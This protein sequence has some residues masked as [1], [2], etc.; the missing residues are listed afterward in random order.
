[1]RSLWKPAALVGALAFTAGCPADPR[2]SDGRHVVAK[3]GN[4]ALRDTDLLAA[5]AQRGASRITDPVARAA[6]ARTSLERMIEDELLLAGASNAGIQPTEEEVERE[7]RKRSEGYPPGVFMRVL[8]AEQLTLVRFKERVRRRLIEDAYLRARLS[9]LPAATD[10][11]VQALYDATV[12]KEEKPAAVRA[13]QILV[14]TLEEG[15]HI[16]GQVR[17]KKLTVEDAAMRF[18]TAPEAENGGDLGWFAAGEMPAIFDV[19]F[20]L[21]KGQVSD[22]VASDYGFH[23]FQVI[24]TRPARVEP[25]ESVR[26]HLEQAIA[27]ERQSKA[28]AALLEELKKSVPV[29]VNDDV[30]ARVLTLVPVEVEPAARGPAEQDDVGP[31]A[32]DAHGVNP[33]TEVER[34]E[35]PRAP[36]KAEKIPEVGEP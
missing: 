9:Q 5:L 14:K 18:S 25:L 2:D 35:R 28:T 34:P 11:D 31:R 8:A 4:V 7:L 20:A 24:D 30:V 21:E 33:L 22:V 26:Q 36:P 3:V 27:R 10:E 13:R 12:A 32:L 29:T 16:L 23:I 15:S 1:M 19:C 6:V 17:A